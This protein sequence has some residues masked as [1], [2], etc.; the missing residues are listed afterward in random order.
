MTAAWPEVALLVAVADATEQHL[1]E[2]SA[3]DLANSFR[4]EEVDE[5]E[6]GG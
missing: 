3:R 4:G 6:D 1:D 2:L 5:A